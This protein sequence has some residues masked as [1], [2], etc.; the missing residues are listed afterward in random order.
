MKL[1][2]TPYDLCRRW[3]IGMNQLERWRDSHVGPDFLL[4]NHNTIRYSIDAVED[5]EA[6]IRQKCQY[7]DEEAARQTLKIN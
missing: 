7:R 6:K 3:D 1:F 4:I 2:L 5:F